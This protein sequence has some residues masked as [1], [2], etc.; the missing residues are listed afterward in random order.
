MSRRVSVVAEPKPA[1][2]AVAAAVNGARWWATAAQVQRMT[3][4]EALDHAVFSDLAAE[5]VATLRS[6]EDLADTL[7]RQSAGYGT[8]RRLR[9]DTGADPAA[10]LGRAMA[11]A[12]AL[13]ID[14]AAAV[15][16]AERFWSAVSHIGLDL[17]PEEEPPAADSSVSDAGSDICPRGLW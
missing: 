2:G 8:G 3:R 15:R 7:A 14:L 17:P 16:D 9:D 10:R 12:T 1:C 13:R 4:A 6:L 5:L 11:E